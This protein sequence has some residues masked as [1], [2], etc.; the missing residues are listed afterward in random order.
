MDTKKNIYVV[1]SGGFAKEVYFLIKETKLYDFKGFIEYKSTE[2]SLTF[3][4][5]ILPVIDEDVFFNENKNATIAIGVGRPHLVKKIAEK[6]K[7][8]DT[9]NIIHPN[10]IGD[11]DNIISGV[12]NIITSGVIFTTNITIG[13]F[14]VFNLNMTVGHDT[15]IGDYNV[16]NPSTNI[17]GNNKIGTKN[18]FGVGSISLENM[19]IGDN[20]V[21]GAASLITKNIDNNGVYIGVPSKLIKNNDN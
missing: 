16:F 2:K 5:E 21:I 3:N 4:G 1:G 10:F 7:H 14:N 6:F 12:G 17:S 19:L 11:V 18:L 20:N 8:F 15:V 13:S 9:P